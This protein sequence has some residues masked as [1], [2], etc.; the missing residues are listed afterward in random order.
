MRDREIGQILTYPK[1][2]LLTRPIN[3]EFRGEVS[4]YSLLAD[5]IRTIEGYFDIIVMRH[6]ESGVAATFDI[7]IINAGDGPGQHLTQL[8]NPETFDA[9][10]WMGLVDYAWSHVVISDEHFKILHSRPPNHLLS[11]TQS[12]RSLQDPNTTTQVFGN[13]T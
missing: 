9:E 10:D 2:V 12:S 6:F 11:Q 4:H 13:F 7:P 5:T 3:L 8:G 1:A